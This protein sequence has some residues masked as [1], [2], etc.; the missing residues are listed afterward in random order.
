M[1]NTTFNQIP[2]TFSFPAPAPSRC[3]DYVFVRPNGR[4]VTVKEAAILQTLQSAD[5][6]T[7]SDH[8]PVVLTVAIE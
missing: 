3:I 2:L 7:A 8:L 5:P 6:A 4:K 1:D